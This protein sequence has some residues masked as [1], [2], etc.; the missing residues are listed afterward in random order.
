M[1]IEAAQS[2]NGIPVSYI[3]PLLL[4]QLIDAAQGSNAD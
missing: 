2:C 4:S 3:L 1:L